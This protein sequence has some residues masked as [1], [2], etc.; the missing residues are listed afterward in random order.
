LGRFRGRPRPD[1]F[2][3]SDSSSGSTNLDS[4]AWPAEMTAARGTPL[5][6]TSRWT[7]VPKP[8]RERPN[9]WPSGSP[10]PFS[11]PPARCRA[12]GSD[13]RGVDVPGL[14][15]DPPA[16]VQPHVEPP[17]DAVDRAVLAP[18]SE[19]VVDALPTA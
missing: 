10:A 9:A 11:P 18:A 13:L 5:P 1:R 4:W 19:A 6:S 16:L 7:L 2:S 14:D 8:P 15:V 3:R 17:E 12:A